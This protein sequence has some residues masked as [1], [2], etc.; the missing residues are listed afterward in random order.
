[1]TDRTAVVHSSGCMNDH[2]LR[3]YFI[4]LRHPDG[5]GGA[6]R[7]LAMALG[8]NPG[9]IRNIDSALRRPSWRFALL[10][11]E[12]VGGSIRAEEIVRADYRHVHVRAKSRR[13]RR[14]AV[15]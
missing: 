2:P 12:A 15:G 1:M 4:S 13:R 6:R 10:I 8:C 11:E 5:L 14:R 7:D 3:R 9:S